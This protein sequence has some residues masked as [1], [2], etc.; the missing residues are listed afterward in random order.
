VFSVSY[1]PSRGTKHGQYPTVA[2]ISVVA[3]SSDGKQATSACL[4]FAVLPRM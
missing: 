2:W 4:R 1:Q 3:K